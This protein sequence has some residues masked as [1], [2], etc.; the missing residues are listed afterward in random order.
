MWFP[1]PLW[2]RCIHGQHRHAT[3]DP[4]SRSCEP[5]AV[6]YKTANPEEL[7]GISEASGDVLVVDL[8]SQ[9]DIRLFEVCLTR[10]NIERDIVHMY[11]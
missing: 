9:R 6:L 1:G 11:K 2:H 5:A 3:V 7:I 8:D 10:Y 4:P